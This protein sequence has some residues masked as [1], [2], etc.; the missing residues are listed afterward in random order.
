MLGGSCLGKSGHGHTLKL[1]IRVCATDAQDCPVCSRVGCYTNG[2]IKKICFLVLDLTD[3]NKAI[4]Y[5]QSLRLLRALI[6]FQK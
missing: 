2:K 6:E 3:R 1:K 4:L 5:L